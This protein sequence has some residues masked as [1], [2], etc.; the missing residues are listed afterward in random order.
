MIQFLQLAASLVSV[1]ATAS[2]ANA[3]RQQADSRAREIEE[4]KKRNEMM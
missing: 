3:A 2:A 1:A 4:D